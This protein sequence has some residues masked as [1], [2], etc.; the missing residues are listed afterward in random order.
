MRIFLKAIFVQVILNAYVIWR[1]W[2]ILPPKKRYRIPYIAFFAVEIIIYLIGFF[3]STELPLELRHWVAWLGT[4]WMVVLIYGGGLLLGYDLLRFI[5]KRWQIFPSRMN[6]ESMRLRRVY[7]VTVFVFIFGVMIYGNYRFH[8]PTV[9]EK[10]LIVDKEVPNLKELKVVMVSDVHA[11]V[12]IRK[13]ILSMYVD[14]IMEQKPDI[15]LIAGDIIDYDLTS[16]EAQN[17]QEEFRRLK[18]PYGVYGSTGN[19]EY[20][21]VEDSTEIDYKVKWLNDVAGITMLRDTAMLVD[22][23]FYVVGR[24]DD[25]WEGR[26]SLSEIMQGVDKSRPVIVINHEPKNL[27]EELANGA[28]IALYGHTHNGQ[29]FP[30]NFVIAMAFEVGHGYKNKE[31]MHV[32][33]SSGL[34][35]AGPQYRIGTISEIVVLNVQFGKEK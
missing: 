33:V 22:S 30:Y 25:K 19:H 27:G 18:A 20:V 14:R 1:G 3:G 23:A 9:T 31:G 15:I 34:G 7:F 16:V 11:G 13:D 10:T 2:Q 6:L 32:Y 35:L 26:K 24:E 4:T 8:H 17:M 28:D 29:L 12:L 5:N 21:W